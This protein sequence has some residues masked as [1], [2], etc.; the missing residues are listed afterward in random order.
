MLILFL[1]DAG[2]KSGKLREAVGITPWHIN[3]IHEHL[4]KGSLHE[5]RRDEDA[6]PVDHPHRIFIRDVD[7]PV[8]YFWM[9]QTMR[10]AGSW[11]STLVI[12]WRT[13]RCSSALRK[14]GR[15]AYS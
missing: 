7:V 9:P 4:G 1:G 2:Q 13:S 15:R 14:G 3:T 6:L 8:S 5:K 11:G 10:A 12:L